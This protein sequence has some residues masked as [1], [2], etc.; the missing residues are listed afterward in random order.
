MKNNKYM[1]NIRVRFAP[2]PTGPLHIGGVRTALYNYLFAKKNNGKFVLRIEDTDQK[3]FVAGAEKYIL[4]S[5]NWC[6]INPDESPVKEGNYAPYRQSERKEI[7]LQYAR[8]LIDSGWA[9]YAF[10]KQEE[11]DKLRKEYE[12]EKKTFI[13]NHSQRQRLNN[14]FTVGEDILKSQIDKGEYVIRFKIPVNTTVEFKDIIRGTIK[15][16]S[17]TLDDKIIFKSD[18]LPTYHL[19]NVIDDHLMEISHVIRGEEWLPSTPLHILLYKAFG[20]D[21]EIPAFAHL[22]LLLKPQG[23][24]KLSKRDG[25]KLGFPVFPLQWTDDKT[26]EASKGYKE[27]GYFPDAFINILAFLGWNPGTEKEFYSLDELIQ[28]FSLEKVT[29]AGTRFDPDKAKWYNHK[30]LQQKSAEELY[31]YIEPIAKAEGYNVYDKHKSLKIINLV[32]ERMNFPKDFI[33]QAGFF[34]KEPSE[35]DNKVIKKKWKDDIPGLLKELYIEILPNSNFEKNELKKT[36]SSWI[37]KKGIGFGNIMNCL[38]LSLVG[39]S[40]GPDLFEIIEILGKEET[41]KRIEKAVSTI[42]R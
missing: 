37:E 1:E 33:Q 7:Y 36:V 8:K 31:K 17:D 10:D 13:Y 19:A 42:K 11:L 15:V 29:K 6:K 28:D 4:D 30:Y 32:K 41:I 34:Y 5:F 27:E 3:R 12:K 16:N 23:K 35:Y 26:G 21:N 9:Y 2:S 24:G 18:G 39:G 40:K 25:D 14:Q 22:P 20:W 38:R